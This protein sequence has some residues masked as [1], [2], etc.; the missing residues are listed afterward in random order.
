M[1]DAGLWPAR[2][3]TVLSR[4]RQGVDLS[5]C[6]SILA[7]ISLD[8]ALFAS[9]APGRRSWQGDQVEQRVVETG[10]IAQ[11]VARRHALGSTMI[12]SMSDSR[13]ITFLVRPV[14]PRCGLAPLPAR[15]PGCASCGAVG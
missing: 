3:S 13:S 6:S 10:R 11:H 2:H 7:M 4:G 12:P 1:A 14:Q 8:T 5:I 15:S 9:V